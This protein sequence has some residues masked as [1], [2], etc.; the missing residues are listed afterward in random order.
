MTKTR[1][2]R[3]NWKTKKE[4]KVKTN[5]KNHKSWGLTPKKTMGLSINKSKSHKVYP[6]THE[7]F[8]YKTWHGF[9]PKNTNH[10]KSLGIP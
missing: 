7:I 6:K 10:H 5:P 2:R 1:R 3:V 4:R 8:E 9:Y